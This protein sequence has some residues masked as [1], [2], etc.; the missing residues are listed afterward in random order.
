MCIWAR[1]PKSANTLGLVEHAF[2]RVPLFTEWI[3]GRSHKVIP[4]RPSRHSATGTSSSGTSSSGT[5]GSRRMSLIPA[6][7]KSSEKDSAVS[8]SHVYWYRDGN[9]NCLLQNTA[10]W[11]SHCQPISK[12]SLSTLFC[13][14]ILDH[15]VSSINSVSGAKILNSYILLDASFLPL[16]SICENQVLFSSDKSPGHTISIRSWVSQT[17]VFLIGTI[18]PRYH[19]VGFSSLTIKFRPT[20]N[21]ISDFR[22]FEDQ[23]CMGRHDS[24]QNRRLLWPGSTHRL[25]KQP[26]FR[27]G[28]GPASG[29]FVPPDWFFF[30]SGYYGCFGSVLK[31]SSHQALQNVAFDVL[32]WMTKKLNHPPNQPSPLLWSNA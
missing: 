29:S 12:N 22:H 27:E 3:G 6:A 23:Q 16:S 4:A 24:R 10:R 8:F 32:L 7:Q 2:W 20:L 19:Q 11:D 26:V 30:W 21:R 31:Q 9:C 15:G 14:L 28:N 17:L 5:S 18:L 13:P 1:F 25:S